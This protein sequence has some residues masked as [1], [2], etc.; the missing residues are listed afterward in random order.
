MSDAPDTI[1]QAVAERD[2]HAAMAAR[3]V[4]NYL[5]MEALY[6]HAAIEADRLGD[7]LAVLEAELADAQA[8]AAE[9]QAAY[10]WTVQRLHEQRDAD[11]GGPF[12]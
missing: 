4:G 6:R 5:Q 3:C 10:S 1:A 7:R 8:D 9:W 2:A 11:R 12:G